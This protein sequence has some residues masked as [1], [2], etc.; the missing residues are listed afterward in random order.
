MMTP[1]QIQMMLHYY[2]QS[3]PY[4]HNEPDHAHSPAVIEQRDALIDVGL[5]ET[6]IHTEAGYCCTKRG[7]V[8]VA[9]LC[10]MG[11]P[12]EKWVLP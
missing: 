6:W 4:A 10:A 9:L 12:V 7:R 8:Y 2:A 1:L 3:T 11:L 5:L